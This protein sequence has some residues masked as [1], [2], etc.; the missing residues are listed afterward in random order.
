MGKG[1]RIACIF[2]P[3]LLSIGALVCLVF[4]GL[5][6]TNTKAPLK[7]IYF[8]KADLK[9]LDLN[10]KGIP[11]ELLPFTN[12]LQQ[13]DAS[14]NLH[15]FY[16]VGLWNHCY[17]EYENGEFKIVRCTDRKAKYWF[18]PI[19]EWDL[20]DL[21][22]DNSDDKFLPDNLD[23]GLSA[24]KK[25]AGW[26]FIA[27][28]VAFVAT[29]VEL[30]V[31]IAAVFSR[32]GSLVVTIVSAVSSVFFFAAAITATAMYAALTAAINTSLKPYNVHAT[33]GKNMFATLWLGVA[34][35][36]ASG[37]FWLFSVCCCSGR[38]PYSHSNNAG[39]GIGGGRR[40]T[41]GVSGITAEKTPY[42][43]ERVSDPYGGAGSTTAPFMPAA[44]G[45]PPANAN[46]RD[47]A[48]E[49]FR[50]HDARA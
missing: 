36:L 44:A 33:L 37:V 49:P 25:V 7:N 16:L 22:E 13:A 4:V 26:M 23:K 28:I 38:S 8:V 31:G 41:R 35:S 21:V 14:G 12:S 20:E 11:N 39:G 48:Y 42:T 32:W 24:Y 17:G 46:G 27:F 34:F 9:D 6:V 2:T 50:H 3:Y 47:M 43:Y 5:G 18:N 30:L 1:G 19:D 10:S 15:D 40:G 29:C 45:G